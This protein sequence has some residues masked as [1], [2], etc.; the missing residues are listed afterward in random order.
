MKSLFIYLGFLTL[1]FTLWFGTSTVHALVIT[2]TP[3]SLSGVAEDEWDGIGKQILSTSDRNITLY[4]SGGGGDTETLNNLL[5]VFSQAKAQGK[6]ITLKLTGLAGSA[7]AYGLCF[8]DRVIGKDANL[9]VYHVEGKVMNFGKSKF[10]V[11]PDRSSSTIDHLINKCV[12]KGFLTTK[13]VDMMWEGY[14]V[15]KIRGM[16]SYLNDNRPSWR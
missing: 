11:R 1:I 9:I 13:D 16:T 3:N 12:S 4:W 10:E 7:F 8:A 14:E 6:T 5:K 2:N 15:H